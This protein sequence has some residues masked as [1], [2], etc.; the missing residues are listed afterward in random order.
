M[1]SQAEEV[2]AAKRRRRDR[3]EVRKAAAEKWYFDKLTQA[4]E[5]VTRGE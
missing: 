2:R 4:L 5:P 1:T 3:V